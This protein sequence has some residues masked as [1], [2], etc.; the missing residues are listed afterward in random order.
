MTPSLS[1]SNQSATYDLIVVSAFGRGQ[2][3][4]TELANQGWKTAMVDV[5]DQVAAIS[6]KDIEGPFGLFESQELLPSQRARLADEGEFAASPVGFS[7]LLPEGPLEFRSELTPFLLRAR[8]I[9]EDVENYVR[10]SGWKAK[11]G[12]REKRQIKKLQYSHS[13]LAQFA[14]ALTSST[15]HENH[16]ALESDSAA[17]LFSPYGIRQMTAAGVAKGFQVAKTA[18][19]SLRLKSR[20]VDIRLDGKS[21]DAIEIKGE[22]S[23]AERARTFVWCLSYD[24]TKRVSESLAT[25]LFP[26]A[27]PEPQWAWQRLTFET[28]ASDLLASLPLTL[29][30]LDD[31]DLAWTRANMVLIRRREGASE[32]DAWVKVPTWMRRETDVFKGVVDEVKALLERKLPGATLSLK[33]EMLSPLQWPIYTIEDSSHLGALKSQNVF[34]D[35]PGFWPSVDWL[36][37]FKVESSIIDK[38]MKL[39]SIW[40]AAERKAER[41]AEA[42]RDRQ[43]RK[44]A[45][46]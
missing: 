10:H 24:E 14:H 6:D 27:W 21:A 42:Q 4:A 46:P 23:G 15:Q 39:K 41:K 28:S 38:L 36:G 2:W 34:F 16:I 5:S 35:A 45:Q 13:W 7:M 17:P 1:Q 40:D 31:V 37:R 25:K 19:V 9:P 12:E 30:I 3:I 44:G 20:V 8:D 26:K 11:E 32:F 43:S 22:V 33:G 18:G 29:A